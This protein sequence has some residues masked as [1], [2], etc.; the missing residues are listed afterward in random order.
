MSALFND[1]VRT[2]GLRPGE[3]YRAT[4]D[5]HTVEVRVLKEDD[6]PTPEL[7]EMVM[8]DGIVDYPSPHPGFPVKVEFGTLPLPDPPVITP[9]DYYPEEPPE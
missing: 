5:G 7:A 3:T 2:L 4:V 9:D 8:L 1:A 6:K